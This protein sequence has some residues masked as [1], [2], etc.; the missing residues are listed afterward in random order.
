MARILAEEQSAGR[1]R[2]SPRAVMSASEVLT[3]ESREKIQRAWNC[4]PFNVY[5]ATET[6]GIASECSRHRL[7]LFEDLVIAEI[8]DE[9]LTAVQVY[10]PAGPE[11]RFKGAVK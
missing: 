11:Q 8:V 1:L 2:I 9:K 7:H 10:S 5:A 3:K 4:P 6:A